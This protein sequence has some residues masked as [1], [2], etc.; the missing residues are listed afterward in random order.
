MLNLS[1]INPVN[2]NHDYSHCVEIQDQEFN[3]TYLND[4]RNYFQMQHFQWNYYSNE[5][6]NQLNTLHDTVCPRYGDPNNATGEDYE[7]ISAFSQD[8][9]AIK[10]Q[11]N[12]FKPRAG[13]SI[14]LGMKWGVA[15][16]DPSTQDIITTLAGMGEA[17]ANFVGR[18]VAFDDE[19]T[20]KTVVL[21]TDGQ[22]D[23]SYRI[24]QRFYNSESEVVHW[25]NYNLQYYFLH[26]VSSR[27]R[28]WFY[29]LHYTPDQGDTLMQTLCEE[30][31]THNIVIWTIGFETTE[32]GQ[33]EMRECA[34]SQSH[35][36]EVNGTEI[37]DAFESIAR[38]I[39]QLRLI[40]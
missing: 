21:M 32:H 28:S 16:L 20:L 38:Y 24:P 40:Q 7:A 37:T 5:S 25:S 6:G 4:N 35:F 14:H 17:D 8:A 23:Y 13:T 34:S 3:K 39:N 36:F 26:Y 12:Q 19:E 9:A 15:L 22:N 31:K 11:I 29:E 33:D 18:P 2:P 10:A 1:N 27:Y 30:A